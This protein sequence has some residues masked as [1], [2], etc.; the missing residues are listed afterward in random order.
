M[1]RYEH[2]YDMMLDMCRLCI[3]A[4]YEVI[5]TMILGFPNRPV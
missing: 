3:R 5:L 4:S 2:V 1:I